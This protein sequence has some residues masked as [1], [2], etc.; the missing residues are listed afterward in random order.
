MAVDYYDTAITDCGSACPTVI[1]G[2]FTGSAG[3]ETNGGT[4]SYFYTYQR[5]LHTLAPVWAIHPYT[6]VSDY[7]YCSA[8]GL[9]YPIFA[10]TYTGKFDQA[11]QAANLTAARGVQLWLNE[12]T[13]YRAAQYNPPAQCTGGPTSAPKAANPVHQGDNFSTFR[14]GAAALWLTGNLTG[15]DTQTLPGSIPAGE[16]PLTT[17]DYF[18]IYNQ[19][20]TYQNILRPGVEGC[21]WYSLNLRSAGHVPTAP[22]DGCTS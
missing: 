6:D 9:G 3:L 5:N 8:D 7:E 12:I 21:M 17:V 16:A 2:D 18:R 15:T 22:A 14:V 13:V 19:T 20:A 4:H 11:L 1:A 10:N